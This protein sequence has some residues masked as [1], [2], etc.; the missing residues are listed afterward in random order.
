[1]RDGQIS[2]VQKSYTFEFVS[3]KK[4]LEALLMNRN[5]YESIVNSN[6]DLNLTPMLSEYS[7]F[8]QNKKTLKLILFFNEIE[9]KNPLG[10]AAEAF[11]KWYGAARNANIPINY[12]VLKE[13]ALSHHQK[14]RVQNAEIKEAFEASDGWI[15]KFL[16]RYDLS[17]KTI[18]EES[19]S[20]DPKNVAA[21]LEKLHKILECYEARDI[22]NCDETGL[23]YRLGP[24]RTIAAKSEKF[25]AI[26]Y[27]NKYKTTLY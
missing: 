21:S 2:L 15:Q 16:K 9:V 23:Y 10:H 22:Y 12:N 13:K 24:T 17:F 3:I 27:W 4:S 18:H 20:V 1:M 14:L 11:F 25:E 26:R 19:E 8:W 5:V 7:Q 6:R